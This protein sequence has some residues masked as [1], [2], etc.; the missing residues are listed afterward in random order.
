MVIGGDNSA[1]EW[2]AVDAAIAHVGRGV[3]GYDLVNIVTAAFQQL[4]VAYLERFTPTVL[5]AIAGQ[6]VCLGHIDCY[7]EEI[8]ILTYRSQHWLRTSFVMIA[9]GELSLLGSVVSVRDR[10]P[11]FSGQ[12]D[13]PFAANAPMSP[14]YPEVHPR[15]AARRGHRTG[16][17]LAQ[18]AVA[19]RRGACGLRA[20]DARYPQ[21]APAGDSPS[22]RRLPGRR[23]H[24]AIVGARAPAQ[25]PDWT[26]P[27][28]EQLAGRNRDAMRIEPL[29]SPQPQPASL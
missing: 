4:Y 13:A 20:E 5:D 26:T 27:W 29:L 7:N 12:S 3:R 19:R 25:T 10:E 14:N 9:P 22:R 18:V 2:S 17:P 15:L 21:R 6:R 23:R 24:L 16:R 28:W 8:G 11:W 1:S